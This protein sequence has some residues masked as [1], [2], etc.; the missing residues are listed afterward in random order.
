VTAMPVLEAALAPEFEI[1]RPLG[2]GGT[3]T[4]YLARETELRR[5]VAI[6]VPH[7][8]LAQDPLV[9]GR[10]ERE[11]RAAARLRHPGIVAVHRIARL[12]DGTPYLVMEYIEGRTLDDALRADGPLPPEDALE[13]LTRVAEALAEAHRHGVIH[14]DVRPGNILC[15]AEPAG[16]VLTDFGIAGILESGSEV[17]TRLTRPGERLGD[18]A[19]RSPEQLLGEPITPAADVYGWGLVAFEALTGQRPF[20]GAT[21]EV[22]GALRLRQPPRSLA[23]VDPDV[24]PRLSDLIARCLARDPRHRPTAETLAPKLARTRDSPTGDGAG[25]TARVGGSLLPTVEQMPALA[26]FLEELRRRRVFNV[27]IGYAAIAFVLL[28]GAE[29]ILPALPVHPLAYPLVVAITLA[30]FPVAMVL[31]WMFDLTDAGLRRT[32]SAPATGPAFVRWFLPTLG[33]LLSLLLAVI[34]GWW[35]LGGA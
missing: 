1:L 35:V 25:V 7:P 23:D 31:A 12:P 17:V 13:L 6:K 15:A 29:L 3:G 20:T 28:Q 32:R 34:I 30:G 18:A 27:A 9:R 11:A 10:F 24:D 33:L 2:S 22:V 16:A 26:P 21:P 4:V 8:D 5:L 19:Y 14:R